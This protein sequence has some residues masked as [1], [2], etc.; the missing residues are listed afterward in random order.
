MSDSAS[1]A[2]PRRPTLELERD[3][4]RIVLELLAQT[5]VLGSS[6]DADLSLAL[7]GLAP[8]HVR[9]ER[10]GE[11]LFAVALD[12]Q[13]PLRVQ[14]VERREWL[15]RDGDAVELGSLRLVF[16][17]AEAQAQ[18]AVAPPPPVV[19]SARPSVAPARVAPTALP[20]VPLARESASS[21]P[22][23]RRAPASTGW[24][25]PAKLFLVLIAAT[26]L[27]V[28]FR[29]RSTPPKDELPP[30]SKSY[31][32][33]DG[34]EP[35][36][37]YAIYPISE[38]LDAFPEAARLIAQRCQDLLA[39]CEDPRTR[40]LAERALAKARARVTGSTWTFD[41]MRYATENAPTGGR[42]EAYFRSE[43]RGVLQAFLATN[44][45]GADRFV[46]EAKLK[47]LDS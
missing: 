35:F 7:P 31:P 27:V 41:E 10:E 37:Y 17:W 21:E 14:G 13:H 2:S 32:G 8:R 24:P 34:L 9:F 39:S 1:G 5:T 20:T 40:V 11:R 44:P 33:T 15:L 6:P 4:E 38:R 26:A 46:A 3:G 36:F 42:D 16:R 18:R 28:A 30:A 25:W 47:Q 43:K 29:N 19:P 12:A 22:R 45:G 23:E